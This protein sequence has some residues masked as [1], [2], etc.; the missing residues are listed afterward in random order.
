MIVPDRKTVRAPFGAF[1]GLNPTNSPGQSDA[2][3]KCDQQAVILERTMNGGK[4]VP[5]YSAR[6]EDLGP[7]DFVKAQC[8]PAATPK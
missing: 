7:G 6:I 2:P 4:M 1:Y 5:L 8:S 3:L